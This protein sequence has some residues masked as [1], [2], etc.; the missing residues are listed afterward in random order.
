VPSAAAAASEL[1][2]FDIA[3]MPLQVRFTL[4]PASGAPAEAAAP[5]LAFDDERTLLHSLQQLRE[6]NQ[7]LGLESNPNPNPNPNPSP[8]PNPNPPNPDPYPNPNPN[9]NP[10]PKPNQALGLESAAVAPQELGFHPGVT[11]DRTGQCPIVGNRYKLAEENYDVCEAEFVKMSQEEA[12]AYT[13][14]PPP[15]FRKLKGGGPAVWHLWYSVQVAADGGEGGGELKGCGEGGEGGASAAASPSAA[16]SAGGEGGG[17]GVPLPWSCQQV[18]ERLLSGGLEAG[19]VLREVRRAAAAAGS[20]CE[21]RL[22]EAA[23]RLLASTSGGGGGGGREQ[24][25][26]SQLMAL[27]RELSDAPR[28]VPAPS[29]PLPPPGALCELRE[30]LRHAVGPGSGDGGDREFSDAALLLW[31]L[32]HR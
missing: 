22:G 31:L 14:V 8:N 3:P 7:A 18:E 1:P 2:A 28:A 13:R 25:S 26:V 24:P 32:S 19:A 30:E 23:A 20:A 16:A 9:P 4:G 10:E 5:S 21:A 17:G 15:C 12:A 27:C 6:A 29:P 11:C